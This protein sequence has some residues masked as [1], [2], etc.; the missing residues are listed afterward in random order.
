M[1]DPINEDDPLQ[2]AQCRSCAQTWCEDG[3]AVIARRVGE[4]VVWL[5]PP[6]RAYDAPGCENRFAPLPIVDREPVWFRLS[7]YLTKFDVLPTQLEPLAPQEGSWLLRCALRLLFGADRQEPPTFREIEAALL[8]RTVEP[9]GH[10]LGAALLDVVTHAAEGLIFDAV[11][12]KEPTALCRLLEGFELPRHPTPSRVIAAPT[13]QGPAFW[14][15]VG[16]GCW[17][18][19]RRTK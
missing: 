1:F 2:V 9:E 15:S 14:W 3:N 19:Q 8:F 10:L 4:A 6:T 5:I 18:R 12:D 17:A 11:T 16:R 7:D 13:A